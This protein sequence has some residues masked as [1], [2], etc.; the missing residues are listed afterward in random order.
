LREEVKNWLEQAREDYR[1]AEY[2][3]NGRKYYV[4]AFLCQQSV[5]K[6]LKALALAK[7]KEIP[8]SHSIVYLSK[9]VK[10]PPKMLSGI[11]NLN[12]EYMTTRY[13]DIAGGIPAEMYDKKIVSGYL[14]TAK[15]V[16]QWV[17]EQ[18]PK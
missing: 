15:E 10:V 9:M 3:H 12:S 8:R 6:A 17:E 16:L 11:R 13:P 1:S 7:L 14:T 5:E 4:A 18:T 2:N